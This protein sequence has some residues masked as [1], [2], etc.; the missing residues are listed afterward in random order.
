MSKTHTVPSTTYKM[1]DLP[2]FIEEIPQEYLRMQVA[3]SYAWRVDTMIVQ[4]VRV[5]FKAVRDDARTSELDTAADMNN[6]LAETAFAEACFEDIGSDSWGPVQTIHELVDLRPRAHAIARAATAGVL[7]WKGQV[8][9]YVEP[10]ISDIF[11]NQGTMKPKGDTLV[12]MKMNANRRAAAVATGKEAIEMAQR[13]YERKVAKEKNRL[14]SMGEAL[15]AQVGALQCM[16]NIALARRPK[17][18]PLNGI[19]FHQVNLEG[20]RLLIANTIS[21]CERAEDW[22][23]SDSNVSPAECDDICLTSDLSVRELKKVLISPRF[24]TGVDGNAQDSPALR[25]VVAPAAPTTPKPAPAKP[26][27]AKK[28]TKLTDITK[29]EKPAPKPRTVK[30]KP[31]K[32]LAD[33]ADLVTAPNDL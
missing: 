26:V 2:D 21:A 15:Q 9:T 23:E 22:A 17:R 4:A 31:V 8:R 14:A 28:L 7:D 25:T 12:K 6:A 20:Q 33:L 16:F 10:D 32:A 29:P 11:H 30:P 24:N 27:E 1:F 18:M 3:Q 13:L 19:E 5:L